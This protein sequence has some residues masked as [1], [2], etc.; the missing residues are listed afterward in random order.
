MKHLFLAFV[1]LA[2]LGPVA[3]QETVTQGDDLS[4]DVALDGRL[5]I[6]LLNSIWIVPAGGGQAQQITDIEGPAKR[7][8]WSPLDDAIVYQ[9]S[10]GGREQLGLYRF[11]S[12]LVRDIGNPQF[13]NQHATWH[14]LGERIIF[15]SDRNGSGFD[16]WEFDLETGLSWRVSHRDGD[17]LEP[18]WSADGRDLIYIHH[19]GEKWRIMLRRFGMPDRAL[20]TSNTRL[21]ALQWRPDGSLLTFQRALGTGSQIDMLILSDP[22]LVRPLVTGEDFESAPVSWLNRQE[23][24]YTANGVLRQRNFNSWSSVN[25]PFRA[26]VAPPDELL[27]AQPQREL[28]TFDMPADRLIVRAAKLFDGIGGGYQNDLDIIIEGGNIVALEPQ[29]ERPGQVVV[30][31]GPATVLPG[32]IDSYSD[33]PVAVDDGFGALLL[34]LGITTMI[35]DHP[36]V[37]ELDRRWSSKLTPG[38]RLLAA[39][40][41]QITAALLH[42]T[43]SLADANTPGIQALLN[44]RQAKYLPATTLS[45]RFGEM[46]DLSKRASR[47]VAAS[48]PNDLPPGMALHGEFLALAGA[49]LSGEQ[50]LRSAGV[51]A[52]TLLNFGLKLGRIA[53][54]SRADL[55]IVDGDPLQNVAD[56]RKV[57]GVVRNGR[58]FSAIGLI[59]RAEPTAA[60]E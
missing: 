12:G 32:Y 8:R 43:D 44:A 18:T 48:Q 29:Q 58:F 56:L 38:P 49:G 28:S 25:V 17:E 57:V 55:V 37:A 9:T 19:N 6:D 41:D 36:D 15:S 59:E 52:A 13:L 4:V 20:L 22:V 54:G 24:L 46:P 53:P 2:S 30:D 14:P 23:F 5:A 10:S 47:V 27:I 50:V 42:A 35:V 11:A 26:T 39:G 33:F 7:P 21:F 45:R 31:L 60:V 34:S 51:N 3:A 16:L 1:F 40:S